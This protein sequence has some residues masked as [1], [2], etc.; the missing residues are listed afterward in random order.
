MTRPS[1]PNDHDDQVGRGSGQPSGSPTFGQPGPIPPHT[2]WAQLPPSGQSNGG[3]GDPDERRS[4]IRPDASAVAALLVGVPWFFWSLVLVLWISNFLGNWK[5]LVVALWILSGAITF[6]GPVEDLIA[7]YLYRLRRPTLIEDQR[8]G[9]IW[10]QVERRAGVEGGRLSVWIQESDDVNATPTPGH[11]VAVTR[12]ALYTLPPSHL[13][14]V[15]AHELSH[16]AGG[17]AWLSLLTFWYSIPARCA[18]IA[19]RALVQLM[20]KVPALGCAIGGFLILAYAGILL[21]VFTFG[22]GYSTAFLFLTPFIAPPFLAWLSRWQVRQADRRTATI[23]YGATLV[24]VLYGWQ[25]QNQQ[26]LGRET[27]RRTQLMSSTPSLAERVHA[28]ERANQTMPPTG[29]V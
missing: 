24:Q 10:Q 14:A 28:L 11:T 19:V 6:V 9:P 5:W 20:R 13:E 4:A 12:W 18:L 29:Q 2:P 21:A 26:M 1:E 7:R 25:M 27:S 15:L 3:V 17:R 8:L 23:G 16:H 22:D